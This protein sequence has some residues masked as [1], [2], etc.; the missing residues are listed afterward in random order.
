MKPA[1]FD[2][3]KPSSLDEALALLA[4][5]GDEATLLAGGQSLVATLNMRLSAPGLL[6]DLNG[7]DELKGITVQ[8][9]T[10]RIGALTRHTDV[11]NSTEVSEKLPLLA[12]AIRQVAHPAIRNRGTIG[13]SVAFADPAAEY[14]A[15]AVALEAQIEIAGTGGRRKVAAIDFFKD[16]YDTD[17]E[18]GEIITAV[19]FPVLQA[20]YKSAFSELA[21]RHGDYAMA[22]LAVH[23]KVDGTTVSNLR[24]VYF[25]VGSTA[26]LATSAAAA[27]E[28]KPVDET[29]IAAAQ[30]ALGEDLDPFDDMASSGAMKLH[31]AKELT[32][33]VLRSLTGQ[34]E[35]VA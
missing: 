29:N 30:A 10:V 1:P 22:G 16:I 21:R 2:Y 32:G 14:P 26:V 11:E 12:S 27:I 19:E 4:E 17:L 13:G 6:V 23:A 35:I 5:H 7:I 18:E 24:L 28:G 3:I 8:G 20:G 9:D 33:R 31:L 34:E 25:A 15:C